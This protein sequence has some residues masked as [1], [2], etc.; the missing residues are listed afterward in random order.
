MNP[1]NLTPRSPQLLDRKSSLLLVIDLQEKL[2]PLV[3]EHRCI[4]WNAG[5]LLRAAEQLQIAAVGTEQYP[6]KLGQSVMQIREL[7]PTT[8][9][10]RMFSCREGSSQFSRVRSPDHVQ[11]VVCGIETHV[12]VLQT[13]LDFLPDWNVH[14]VVD[15]VGSRAQLDHQTALERMRSAG[16][17]LTT[18]ESV[19]F[20]WCETSRDESFKFISG[21]IRESPPVQKDGA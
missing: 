12:C 11:L 17:V 9:E 10:K 3:P 18:S 16:A 4:L 2:L 15:A 14:V 20:E 8:M 21:L 7:L 13:V 1:P 5:R 19:L 6:D